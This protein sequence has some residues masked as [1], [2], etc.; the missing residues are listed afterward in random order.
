L[1]WNIDNS[2]CRNRPTLRV[3]RASLGVAA[4]DSR[5]VSER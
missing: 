2:Y 1:P 5:E 3:W 4:V